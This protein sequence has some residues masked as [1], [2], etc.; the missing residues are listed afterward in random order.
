MP[1]P[2][3]T[4]VDGACAV[5]QRPSRPDQPHGSIHQ[6]SLVQGRPPALAQL[7]LATP[8]AAPHAMPTKPEFQIRVAKYC[9][10]KGRKII[11]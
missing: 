11:K 7:K 6:L 10:K 2:R 1:Y 8:H 3:P 9:S 5:H 4:R